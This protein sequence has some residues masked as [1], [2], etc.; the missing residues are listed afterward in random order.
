METFAET[1]GHRREEGK[2]SLSHFPV[3]VLGLVVASSKAR[4]QTP[5]THRKNKT[6]LI[7]LS[8]R[9]LSTVGSCVPMRV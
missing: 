9:H 5:H 2:L 8:V 3:T 1:F 7:S 4:T 6:K